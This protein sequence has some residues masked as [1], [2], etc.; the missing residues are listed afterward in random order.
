MSVQN[1][2]LTDVNH[3]GLNR[4]HAYTGL[5]SA[6]S[7]L[8]KL[9][10]GAVY[11]YQF[12]AVD[13]GNTYLFNESTNAYELA[14]SGG[15]GG[16]GSTVNDATLTIKQGDETLGTFTANA[17]SDKTITINTVDTVTDGETAL[18]TSGAVYTAIQNSI[19]EVENGTY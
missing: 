17:S 7:T 15:G 9:E 13:T 2:K 4:Y 11:G 10:D 12:Y 3:V 1:A 19:T 18:V 16:G 8:P 6:L 14:S 5:E